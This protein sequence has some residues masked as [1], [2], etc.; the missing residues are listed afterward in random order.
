MD[1]GYRIPS[2]RGQLE[3]TRLG[4][5]VRFKRAVFR[6]FELAA[7]ARRPSSVK[8]AFPRSHNANGALWVFVSTIGELNAIEPFLVRLLAEVPYRPLVLLTDRSV[9]R[10]AYLR[11]YPEAIIVEMTGSEAPALAAAVRPALLIVAEIPCR[12]SDA[13]CRFPFAF[14]YEA[15]R[16]GAA[17]CLINGWLYGQE[18]ESRIDWLERLW[19]RRDYLRLFDMLTV[20]NDDIARVLIDE[21]AVPGRTTVT[22]NI[23][24]DAVAGHREAARTSRSGQLL[25]GIR[26]GARPCIVAG[27]VTDHDEQARVLDAFVGLRGKLDRP[28]LVVAPRHPENRHMMT[29]L[30]E[31][32]ARQD[33]S[34][35]LRSSLPDARVDDSVACVVLDTM[36]ELRDFYLAATV[37]YVGRDH[38][39][40]EPLAF[41]KPVF[42]GP[43]WDARYPSY[44]VYRMLMEQGALIEATDAPGLARSWLDLLRDPESYG[45]QRE[46]IEE[47][48]A[49]NQGAAERCLKAVA[50]TRA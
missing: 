21:G 2:T 31:E 45:R 9:Y 30:A 35:A 49:R 48:L 27:C 41:D 6:L 28:L 29:A 25:R 40:L 47:V 15:K 18:P 32:L 42:V 46:I 13:P 43:G 7:E 3:R 4:L 1:S 23:K 34:F 17:V 24:F 12:L 11:R 38:N 50:A 16:T 22:G 19:F 14:A 39:L 37:A 33:I 36:G 26:D 20:Q 10:D 5:A 44:P 8:L